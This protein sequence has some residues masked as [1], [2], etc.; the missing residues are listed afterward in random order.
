[1]LPTYCGLANATISSSSTLTTDGTTTAQVRDFVS[2]FGSSPT[3][4]L[5]QVNL[6]PG[7][8][9]D[10]MAQS[11]TASAT[12][13]SA[14]IQVTLKSPLP[15]TLPPRGSNKLYNASG[16][17]YYLP[18]PPNAFDAT[19]LAQPFI[20][21]L[22]IHANWALLEPSTCDTYAWDYLDNMLLNAGILGKKV[23]LTMPTGFITPTPVLPTG[24]VDPSAAPAWA[25][26]S[27]TCSGGGANPTTISS[28]WVKT[29]FG[30]VTCNPDTIFNPGDTNYQNE[31]KRFIDSIGAR[32]GSNS[33]IV[34]VKATG[35]HRDTPETYLNS[36]KSDGTVVT[37]NCSTATGVTCDNLCSKSFSG[38]TCSGGTGCSGTTSCQCTMQDATG[39]L[40]W[41]TVT[42]KDTSSSGTTGFVPYIEGAQQ[43]FEQEWATKFTAV[44]LAMESTAAPM[45]LGTF[46]VPIPGDTFNSAQFSYHLSNFSNMFVEMNDALGC[47]PA[48]TCT[49][50]FTAPYLP[51]SEQP[52][53]AIGYQTVEPLVG[54]SGANCNTPTMS[55]PYFYSTSASQCLT[56]SLFQ[57][58]NAV[59]G[60]YYVFEWYAA[61]I[62]AAENGNTPAP[63]FELAHE[64]ALGFSGKSE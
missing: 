34:L 60:P 27:S 23:S 7:T 5:Y 37:S 24:Q 32:Y 13:F 48:A 64:K 29:G 55:A 51:T 4:A 53:I 58:F 61:D 16:N 17:Y 56:P 57:A 12:G 14:G 28:F 41:L 9:T 38:V 45:P 19:G 40:G 30:P 42:G 63:W 3:I 11:V 59:R 36:T 35:V 54:V 21:G 1:L 2:S 26:T 8:A 44:A 6:G 52:T 50:I 31:W 15:K 10:P 47:S 18:L 20:D 25:K 22:A 43:T 39:T 49:S 62:D 33:Q 46:N